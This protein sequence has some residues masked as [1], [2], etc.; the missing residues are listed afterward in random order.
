[1]ITVK[2]VNEAVQK[3]LRDKQ[4]DGWIKTEVTVL[5]EDRFSQAKPGRPGP[6]TAYVKHKQLRLSLHWQSDAQA[7]LDEA[8]TD[9]IFPLITNDEKLSMTELLLA[10]KHQPAL[11]KRHQQFKSVLEV[12][13]MMLKSHT[14]IEAFLFL[15]FIAL[16]TEALIEREIRQRMYQLNIAKLPI[17]PEARLCAAPTTERLIYL[18]ENLR[19]HRLVDANGHVHQRFY[20]AL[21]EPQRLVLRLMQLSTKQYLSAAEEL[22]AGA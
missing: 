13:P 4:V 15:Y 12:R 10:Y 21:N 16:L 19:R 7:L 8:R 14:R 2:Q 3:L 6:Q 11:E 18:F 5:E 22:V 17:Y 20:D 1:L 9:G